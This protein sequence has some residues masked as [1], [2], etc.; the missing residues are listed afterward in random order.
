MIATEG[1]ASTQG[2]P[3]RWRNSNA[4][5]TLV[6]VVAANPD[7]HGPYR[8]FLARPRRFG[9][10]LAISVAA[11]AALAL[12][13]VVIWSLLPL[14][15]IQPIRVHLFK[16]APTRDQIGVDEHGRPGPDFGPPTTR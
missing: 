6:Y 8:R 9:T 14:P 2:R 16:G 15:P 3:L 10:G 12:V 4:L 7:P 13:F 1:D 11:H 5:A